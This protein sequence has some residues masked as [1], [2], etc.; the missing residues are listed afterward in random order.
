M[1]FFDT[2]G[3]R[4]PQVIARRI[5]P[6]NPKRK[7]RY[8]TELTRSPVTPE[9]VQQW[10]NLKAMHPSEGLMADH[11][12]LAELNK[13]IIATC[14]DKKVREIGLKAV[15]E[16]VHSYRNDKPRDD[17]TA[18]VCHPL[19]VQHLVLMAGGEVDEAIAAGNHDRPEDGKLLSQQDLMNKLK[20]KE[21]YLG[22]MASTWWMLEGLSHL[23]LLDAQ[24]RDVNGAIKP[25]FHSAADF[26]NPEVQELLRRLM[27][28]YDNYVF[29]QIYYSDCVPLIQIKTLDA[30]HN[31]RSLDRLDARRQFKRIYFTIWRDMIQY[32]AAKKI[33][34]ALAQEMLRGVGDGLENLRKSGVTFGQMRLSWAQYHAH[35]YQKSPRQREMEKAGWVRTGPRA[36]FDPDAQPYGG[37]PVAILFAPDAKDWLSPLGT[38]VRLPSPI[39]FEFPRYY[40]P[41]GET[42]D[43]LTNRHVKVDLSQLSA[44]ITQ[45]FPARK[46]SVRSR[47]SLQLPVL[48]DFVRV[49]RVQPPSRL[50]DITRE[51]SELPPEHLKRA[52]QLLADGYATYDTFVAD[53]G[54]RLQRISKALFKPTADKDDQYLEM[55]S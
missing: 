17:G 40:T 46:F 51:L 22:L 36:T 48:G 34:W 42:W 14:E 11:Q 15:D 5:L 31:A 54:R 43:A 27:S 4:Q 52:Q 25:L 3:G 44:L 2:I 47:K 30:V 41:V 39:E 49:W 35:R 38:D 18:A 55:P 28:D 9:R 26:L 32:D 45:N 19:F 16:L 20:M 29:K 7:Q 53:V 23:P 12:K 13:E 21:D 24:G 1:G 8:P 6:P 50:E 33:T 10:L 37:T